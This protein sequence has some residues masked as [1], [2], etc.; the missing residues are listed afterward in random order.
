MQLMRDAP[1]N[2]IKD[3]L[4]NLTEFIKFVLK[5]ELKIC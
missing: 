2:K 3:S 5:S 4:R 1:F